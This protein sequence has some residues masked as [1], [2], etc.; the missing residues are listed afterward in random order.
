MATK[1]YKELAVTREEIANV[2]SAK[3]KEELEREREKYRLLMCEAKRKIIALAMEQIESYNDD[4]LS[5]IKSLCDLLNLRYSLSFKEASKGFRINVD[6]FLT[7]LLYNKKQLDS[8]S[9]VV[10]I[11]GKR[12][13]DEALDIFNSDATSVEVYTFKIEFNIDQN[14]FDEYNSSSEEMHSLGE[15]LKI[16][17]YQKYL[18]LLIMESLGHQGITE[19][20]TNNIPKI[21]ELQ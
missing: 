16:D 10:K 11:G 19:L 4:K 21:I 14:L 2:Y 18:A 3:K 17:Y 12:L 20:G 8:S 13:E 5:S 1:I 15:E 9:I 7:E 6:Y